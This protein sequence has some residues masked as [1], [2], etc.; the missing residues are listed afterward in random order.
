MATFSSG[1]PII[2]YVTAW[3]CVSSM[4]F[5]HRW[6]SATGST[7]RPMIL[8]LRFSNSGFRPAM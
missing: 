1:S 5:V 7:L 3:P 4:S 8:Q 6:W 2:G